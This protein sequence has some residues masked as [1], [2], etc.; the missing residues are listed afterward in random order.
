MSNSISNAISSIIRPVIRMSWTSDGRS[1]LYPTGN[2]FAGMYDK[3]VRDFMMFEPVEITEQAHKEELMNSIGKSMGWD[4]ASK[5]SRIAFVKKN[6]DRIRSHVADE[7]GTV[8][9]WGTFKDA[10]SYIAEAHRFIATIDDGAPSGQFCSS[11]ATMSGMQIAAGLLRSKSLATIVNLTDTDIRHDAYEM[12]LELAKDKYADI[13]QA[14][15]KKVGDML[16]PAIRD[17]INNKLT[18][19]AGK[20]GLM[21]LTYGSGKLKVM[22]DVTDVL[23]DEG[24]IAKNIWLDGEIVNQEQSVIGRVV[25]NAVDAAGRDIGNEALE[26]MAVVKNMTKEIHGNDSHLVWFDTNGNKMHNRKFLKNKAKFSQIVGEMG[27]LDIK[28]PSREVTTSKY[29][30]DG[31]VSASFVNIVHSFDA[32][33]LHNVVARCGDE[34][35]AIQVV[36]DQFSTTANHMARLDEIIRLEYANIFSNDI[37]MDIVEA[38]RASLG[39]DRVEFWKGE[40]DGVMSND[41]DVNEVINNEYGFA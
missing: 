6:M 24:A 18:R 11:D 26:L 8:K 28:R 2:E 1:R 36:H 22:D 38:N 33:L 35:I 39:D 41:F 37:L 19:Q 12:T 30:L 14:H 13:E 9:D 4:K 15:I 10:I 5:K 29:D 17:I 25:G 40:M 3:E 21:K 32:N 16:I 31:M 34:G 27:A 20:S 7:D 23:V